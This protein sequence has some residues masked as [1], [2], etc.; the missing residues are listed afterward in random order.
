M[1]T[2]ALQQVADAS[3]HR[4]LSSRDAVHGGSQLIEVVGDVEEEMG[5]I[6]YIN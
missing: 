5:D 1:A 2:V 6:Q 4:P 3:L